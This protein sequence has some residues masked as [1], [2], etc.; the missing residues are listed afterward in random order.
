MSFNRSLAEVSFPVL[1][2]PVN[3]KEKRPLLA[4]KKRSSDDLANSKIMFIFLLKRLL[5]SCKE[6]RA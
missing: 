2:S 5:S 1:V 3:T 6:V 4:G